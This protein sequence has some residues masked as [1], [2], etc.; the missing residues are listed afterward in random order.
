M[1]RRGG[2]I[3]DDLI[4]LPWWVSIACSGAAFVVLRFVVALFIPAGPATSANYAL[5]GILGGISTMAPLVALV[6]L[7]PAPLAALRQW[8]ERRLLDSQEGLAAIRTLSWQRFETLVGEAYRRQGYAVSRASEDGG[9]DGGVDLVLKK[10]GSTV[11][12]QC[13][14]W[15]AWG[16]GAP[17]VREVFGVLTA[18]KA[19]GVIIVTSGHFTEEARSFARGKSIDLVDGPQLAELIRAVHA[20]PASVPPP[21]QSHAPVTHA[22]SLRLPAHSAKTSNKTTPPA[23]PTAGVTKTCPKCGA[24]M[25][26]RTAKQGPSVGQQFWGC[27]NFP[28]CRATEAVK[29]AR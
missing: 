17:V 20:S 21:A 19:Q 4:R 5:K 24:A 22:A 15:K 26:L 1:G 7:I 23:P 2:T 9:P 6:L 3:L 11:I 16:V 29:E 8:R 25:V 27:M 12:V 28:R 13:K 10:D 18:R 14:Q